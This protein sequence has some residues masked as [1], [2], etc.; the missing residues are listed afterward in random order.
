ML[1]GELISRF[2][3]ECVAAEAVG[4]LDDFDLA[5]RVSQA[6]ANAELTKGEFASSTIRHFVTHASERE[7]IAVFGQLSE[8]EDPQQT[9]LRH[10]LSA[11]VQPRSVSVGE[12]HVAE[13]DIGS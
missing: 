10:V 13:T 7:W 6:A 3:D 2:D 12:S 1:I 8:S 5:A 4:R 9:F 11:V